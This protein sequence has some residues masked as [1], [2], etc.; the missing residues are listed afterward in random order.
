M[1]KILIHMQLSSHKIL[2]KYDYQM[3]WI[4][5]PEPVPRLFLHS[6]PDRSSPFSIL[7]IVSP[8]VMNPV[9]VSECQAENRI[10]FICLGIIKLKTCFPV[11]IGLG[12]KMAGAGIFP[13]KSCHHIKMFINTSCNRIL[14]EP[15]NRTEYNWKGWAWSFFFIY[16]F[17]E[18]VPFSNFSTPKQCVL[19][20][21]HDRP[22]WLWRDN[23]FWHHH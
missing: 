13:S 7:T 3:T 18:S 8:G 10:K 14:N 21:T 22:I 17:N 4:R 20:N 2:M 9:S 23:A 15:Q 1:G 11:Q 19:H 5:L 16:L 6:V 12:F